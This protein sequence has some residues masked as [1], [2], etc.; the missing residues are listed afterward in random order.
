MILLA[1]LS[2]KD[3]SRRVYNTRRFRRDPS[4]PFE[5][6]KFRVE[7]LALSYDEDPDPISMGDLQGH[8]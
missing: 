7:S 1:E 8:R 5:W 2:A 6:D 3:E 4:N